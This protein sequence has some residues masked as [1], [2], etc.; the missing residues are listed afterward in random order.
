MY[1]LT[2]KDGALRPAY[3]TSKQSPVV[4]TVFANS[5]ARNGPS[6]PRELCA[7]LLVAPHFL[8]PRGRRGFGV[9]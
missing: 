8:C 2:L 6:T 9:Y 5:G 3:S 7:L 1:L 4:C